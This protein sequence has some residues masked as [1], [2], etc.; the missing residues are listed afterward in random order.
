MTRFQPVKARDPGPCA[1]LSRYLFQRFDE[2]FTIGAINFFIRSK[3]CY[4]RGAPR[5]R[6]TW[7]VRAVAFESERTSMEGRY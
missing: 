4:F 7:Q 3:T 5:D 1:I 2:E 6:N